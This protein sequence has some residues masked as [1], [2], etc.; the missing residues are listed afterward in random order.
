[1]HPAVA[2]G[3]LRHRRPRLQRRLALL[4]GQA[5]GG[6]LGFAALCRLEQVVH[7]LGDARQHPRGQQQ[8]DVPWRHDRVARR[9][10]VL[11]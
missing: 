9:Q 8:G 3:L 6:A 5:G 4:H 7:D 10:Q 11:G 1:M 2:I